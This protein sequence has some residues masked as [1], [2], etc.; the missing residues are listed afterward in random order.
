MTRR[1]PLS[2]DPDRDF[3]RVRPLCDTADA[4]TPEAQAA[5]AAAFPD[6]GSDYIGRLPVGYDLLAKLVQAGIGTIGDLRQVFKAST[7]DI[8]LARRLGVTETDL[9]LLGAALRVHAAADPAPQADPAPAAVPCGQT[10]FEV[11]VRAEVQ[12]QVEGRRPGWMVK[13]T[14]V[15]LGSDLDY[16]ANYIYREAENRREDRDLRR[17]RTVLVEVAALAQRAA[18]DVG[19]VAGAG[20]GEEGR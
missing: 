17:I 6:D 8:E 13:V 19:L 15:D 3:P 7:S 9:M 14:L 10:P 2:D 16:A 5:I 4:D 1:N 18:Q 20:D 12:R 11:L